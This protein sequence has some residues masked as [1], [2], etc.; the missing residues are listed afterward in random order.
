MWSV[1]YTPARGQNAIQV[2]PTGP[3]GPSQMED[4]KWPTCDFCSGSIT[5][6]GPDAYQCAGCR[7][8][9]CDSCLKKNVMASCVPICNHCRDLDSTKARLA[10]LQQKKYLAWK[11]AS[12]VEETARTSAG[13]PERLQPYLKKV[14]SVG[15]N[16]LS[17]VFKS[18]QKKTT[19]KADRALNRPVGI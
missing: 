15:K 5:W 3:A 9:A 14:G 11:L 6:E 1:R 4:F 7:A 16:E 17:L 12:Q 8:V 19:W 18:N 13:K 2:L 10:K